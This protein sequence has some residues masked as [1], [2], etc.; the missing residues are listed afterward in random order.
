MA[1]ARRDLLVRSAIW[2]VVIGLW[3]HLSSPGGLTQIRFGIPVIVGS[4]LIGFGASLYAW[5]AYLL[6]ESAPITLSSPTR[7]VM[8]GPYAYVRNPLYLAIG[9]ILLGVSTLYTAWTFGGIVRAT[10]VALG[11]HVAVTWFEEPATRKHLGAAYDR[12]CRDVP[13]WIPRA[14]RPK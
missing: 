8:R 4:V 7:L 6:A 10:I 3:A 11:A 1:D 12:Y 14:S 13:R 2:L 5:S 9:L